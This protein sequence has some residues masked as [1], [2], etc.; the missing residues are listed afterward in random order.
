[1]GRYQISYS[2]K[3]AGYNEA[4]EVHPIWRGIG[5]ALII[6]IPVISYFAGLLV[7][8]ANKL[9]HYILIPPDLINHNGDPYLF[10][11]IIMTVVI[12]FVIYT[13]FML[14]TFISHRLF[15][16]SRYGP[17]DAPPIQRKIR[18]RWK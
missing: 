9:H 5:F 3:H 7:I 16:P 14:I 4:P 11:K 18:R 8:E 17:V 10:L 2:N 12:A 13:V 6:L 1:M 15:G